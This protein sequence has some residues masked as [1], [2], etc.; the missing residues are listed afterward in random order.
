MVWTSALQKSDPHHHPHHKPDH[1]PA[2]RGSPLY[3]HVPRSAKHN[4]G[5]GAERTSKRRKLSPSGNATTCPNCGGSVNVYHG[6]RCRRCSAG[7]PRS[8]ILNTKP[9]LIDGLRRGLRHRRGLGN[10][11]NLCNVVLDNAPC[12]VEKQTQVM[13]E[14]ESPHSSPITLFSEEDLKC[15]LVALKTEYI[16]RTLRPILNK[17][18]IHTSNRMVFN[19]PVDPVLLKLPD[20]HNIIKKPMD[21]GTVK[22]KLQALKY[23]DMHAF[24][25]DVRLVFA[26]ART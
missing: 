9:G 16:Q 7:P 26:N 25:E 8:S 17:L 3:S 20:Y 14:P 2:S 15:H 4:T 13:M 23:L 18:M 1:T 21:L 22:S 19:T 6:G 5:R 10:R 12:A 24:A 11:T